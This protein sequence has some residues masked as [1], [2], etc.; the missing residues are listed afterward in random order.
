MP[1]DF[2]F[3]FVLVSDGFFFANAL[4]LHQQ[5]NHAF[6]IAFSFVNPKKTH[7]IKLNSA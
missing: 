1:T 6:I 2:T 5:K 7:K 4:Y 3:M